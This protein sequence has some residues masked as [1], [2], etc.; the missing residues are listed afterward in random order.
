MSSQ[1]K[2]ARAERHIPPPNEG[3]PAEISFYSRI[4]ADFGQE[5]IVPG[6]GLDIGT[7]NIVAVA[8][9]TS[10]ELLFNSQRNA[11][12]DVRSDNFTTK[13]LAKLGIEHIVMNGKGYVIG[14]PAFELA[15][16]FEKDTRHPM[17][18]GLISSQ[19]PEALAMVALLIER[20]LGKP[21]HEGEPCTISIPADPVDTDHNAI[22][23]RGAIQHIVAKMGYAP[24]TIIE[25]EAVVF[26]EFQ[27]DDFTGIGIS[28]GGGMFNICVS[29]KSVPALSFSTTRGGDWIDVNVS[30]A[31]GIPPSQVCAIKESGIDLTSPN[32]HVEDA[33]AI[34]YQSLIRYTLEVIRNRF[35]SMQSMP[36]FIR[37]VGL[38]CGGGTTL[39]KGFI[40]V[41]RKELD[42]VSFP[43]ELKGVRLAGDPIHTTA[44]GCLNATHMATAD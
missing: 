10:G 26:S 17:R 25:G 15:N 20:V 29:Y 36:T 3:S 5:E 23:H 40:D 14:D 21:R 8:R 7:T 35:A 12:L 24:R 33:I 30:K 38:V 1:K 9:R 22:Y 18:E 11:F 28:C 2:G 39:I 6:K 34:Y 31:V 41:F 16:I 37:P 13:M 43:V 27:E 19:E 4:T 44:T 32:G 42:E